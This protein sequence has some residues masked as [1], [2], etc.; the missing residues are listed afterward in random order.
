MLSVADDWGMIVV[1]VGWSL[2]LSILLIFAILFI[3][4]HLE[5][6]YSRILFWLCC[7]VHSIYGRQNGVALF[8]CLDEAVK[9]LLFVLVEVYSLAYV[10]DV[11]EEG[12][13]RNH[14][15]QRHLPELFDKFNDLL[16]S[17]FIF[18]ICYGQ[19]ALYFSH[20]I[21]AELLINDLWQDLSP[22]ALVL[23][24]QYVRYTLVKFVTACCVPYGCFYWP[25]MLFNLFYHWCNW[26]MKEIHYSF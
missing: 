14:H 4:F 8:V 12:R 23:F 21:F 13:V 26:V 16:I 10:T 1:V 24:P 7:W 5:E 18:I 3:W 2:I 19:Y 11:K 20:Q 6:G 17:V 15:L 9:A 25:E 22:I